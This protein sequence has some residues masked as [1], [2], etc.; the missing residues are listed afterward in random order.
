MS[1]LETPAWLGHLKRA[2]SKN[3]RDAHNRYFQL[4]TMGQD[5]HPR[6]RTLVFVGFRTSAGRCLVCPM[7]EVTK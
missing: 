1:T 5:G 2:V 6:V 4:A 7:P 3:K